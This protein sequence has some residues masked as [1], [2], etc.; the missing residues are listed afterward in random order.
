M[1]HSDRDSPAVRRR[2][3]LAALGSVTGTSLLAGCL[4]SDGSDSGNGNGTGNGDGNRTGNGNGNWDKEGE[5]P[6]SRVSNSGL[7][8]ECPAYDNVEQTVCYDAIAEDTGAVDVY[9]EPSA[10]AFEPAESVD[11]TLHNTSD[12]AF[13]SNFYN[14]NVHKYVG[15]EWYHV[16]PREWNEPL[17]ELQPGGSHTWTLSVDNADVEDDE[18]VPRVSGTEDVS[19]AGIG[20]GHYAFR[21]RGWL[22]DDG[23]EKARALGATVTVDADPIRLTPTSAIESTEWDGET[24]VANSTRGDPDD[25]H[26]TFAA[27]ELQH[28]ADSD[29]EPNSMITEQVLRNDQLRDTLALAYRDGAS[30]VRLEEYTGITPVFGARSDGAVEFQGETFKVTTRE[31]DSS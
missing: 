7:P 8:E 19:L 3:V 13:Q 2:T 11:F 6:Q 18:S 31:L 15:G 21:A 16:A 23:Y 24:L 27:Y 20:G 14:W 5:L 17:M 30:T 4:V 1:T 25:E 22:A 9:L 28:V 10:R 12:R 26:S 29:E